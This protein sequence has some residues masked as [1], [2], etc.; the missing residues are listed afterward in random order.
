LHKSWGKDTF[1]KEE[2]EK[3]REEAEAARKARRRKKGNVEDEEEEI[4][5]GLFE[6]AGSKSRMEKQARLRHKA[7]QHCIQRHNQKIDAHDHWHERAKQHADPYSIQATKQPISQGR[8]TSYCFGKDVKDEMTLKVYSGNIRKRKD[9]ARQRLVHSLLSSGTIDDAFD[10]MD[11]DDSGRIDFKEFTKWCD[12]RGLSVLYKGQQGDLMLELDMDGDG[13]ISR[14]ELKS[15]LKK[16]SPVVADEQ[17]EAKPTFRRR[18]IRSELTY[19]S[20]RQQNF[21]SSLPARL[22]PMKSTQLY[23]KNSTWTAKKMHN[24]RNVLKWLEKPKPM[25]NVDGPSNRAL[26][27]ASPASPITA[28][29]ASNANSFNFVRARQGWSKK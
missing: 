19:E 22:R 5:E 7:G 14:S 17:K 12:S 8:R 25:L 1:G 4:D 3:Q 27:L 6:D 11:T 21:S 9:Q 20:P 26:R 10:Q 2:R 28:N 18:L 24:Q 16:T 15:F 23:A 29:G 13:E